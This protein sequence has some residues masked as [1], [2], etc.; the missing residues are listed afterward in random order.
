VKVLFLGTGTFGRAMLEA[1][2]D[3]GFAP[4]LVVTQPPRRRRRRGEPEPTPVHA[5]ASAR[6]VA[7]YSPEKAN[8]AASLERMRAAGADLFVVAEYGQ[9]LSQALLDI[10]PLGAI[11]AHTSLLPRHRGATPVAAAILAGDAVTGV[12]IQRVVRRLDAGPILAQRTLPIAP[13][14]TTGTLT[15]KLEPLG[16][17]AL[18]AVVAS[19][20]AGDAPDERAQD[21]SAATTC[22]RL[23]PDDGVLDW[24]RPAAEIARRVRAMTP[25]PGARTTLDREPP[26]DLVVRRA[27]PVDG[28]GE[29]GV[30]VAVGG[31]GFDV[32]ASPGLLRILDLVPSA[33]RP[34][35]GRAFVNGYRLSVGER[36][37]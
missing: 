36:F 30:V 35:D 12:T 21:E 14:D 29:P 9:I 37:R 26:L 22:R 8:D 27:A 11:N 33:R 1:L 4:V 34:M 17:E 6:G 31:D 24:R 32:G 18:V 2:L 25:R 10:P 7:V 13:D 19:F 16:A 3:A 20:A 23:T 28:A 5:A 15:A